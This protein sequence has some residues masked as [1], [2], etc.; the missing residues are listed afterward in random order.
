MGTKDI[1]SKE[2]FSNPVFFA[3]A[4]NYLVYDG[5]PIIQPE[6]LHPVDAS[7]ILLPYG[8]EGARLPIERL[9]D[10]MRM[11]AAM[12]DGETV[13]ILFGS[14]FQTRIH[15]AMPVRD[16][17]YTGINYSAQAD[18][19]RRSYKKDKG[20]ITTE[21]DEVRIKLTREEFLSG[22]R[23][24]DKLIPIVSAVIY[25]GAD[26]WDAPI[27]LHEMLNTKNERILKHIPNYFINL[28]SPAD[29]RDEDFQKFNTDLGFAMDAIRRTNADIA[30]F[31]LSNKGR[32]IDRQSAVF[33]N[34]FA[35]LHLE[36]ADSDKGGK[37][38][39]CKS[40]Q[41]YTL[42]T[43]VLA[44]IDAY[45]SLNLDDTEIVKMVVKQLDVSK[46]YVESLMIPVP[47]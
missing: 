3:D 17:T 47:V 32:E 20:A 28:F 23:K 9:R 34:E 11:W 12:E 26:K 21:G 45:R 40:M 43:K 8:K 18:E 42:K 31:L 46:E 38:D 41:E 27:T 10:L 29:F 22:F 36:Y 33:I 6:S 30:E 15:Y 25:L 16:M 1:L 4:F 5:E 14:E 24:T 2:Y 44:Y 37:V 35:D 13:Y 19:A 39:M 7:E